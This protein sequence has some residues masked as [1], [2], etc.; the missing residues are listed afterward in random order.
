MLSDVFPTGF[1]A[2]QLAMVQPGLPVAV[3]GA[4]PVGLL[5]AYSA[6]LQGA[7][8]VFVVDYIPERL[9]LAKDIGAI[10]I[11]FTLSDPVAMIEALRSQHSA[12]DALLPGEKKMHEIMSGI[13]KLAKSVGK[14]FEAARSDPVAM[15][16]MLRASNPAILES[17]LPGEEKMNGVMCGI[18]AVGYQARDRKDPSKENPTQVTNDL[19]RVVNPTGHLGIIGVFTSDDP[20]GADEHAKKGEYILPFGQLW[21]KG[22][23]VGTGQTP[24]KKTVIMLRDMIIAGVAKPSFIIS[25]KISIEEAPGAYR[26]FAKRAE[27]FTKVTIQFEK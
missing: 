20:R 11:D 15:I 2:T 6:L 25:H 4:G 9:K 16:E 17:L 13:E 1:F 22:L 7:A 10:P 19:V 26:E 14:N 24:V 8:Q 21:E 3:F 23:T 18:D 12:V 27:G 5:S